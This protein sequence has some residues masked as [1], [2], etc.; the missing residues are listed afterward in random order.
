MARNRILYFSLF[1]LSLTFVYFYGGKIP[2][3]L[4][5]IVII[6]P[7]VSF[8]FT[9]IA[10]KRF[11]FTESI[12]KKTVIK[13]ES[14]NYTLNIHNPD[15]FLYPFIKVNFYGEDTVFS[16]QFQTKSFSLLPFQKKSF[17]F[18]ILCKYRGYYTVGIKSIEFEDYLGIFRL[19]RRPGATK[20]I[21]VNPRLINL[22]SFNIKTNYM[23]ESHSILNKYFED[24]TTISDTRKYAYGDSLKRIHWKL[25]AKVNQLMVKNFEG[26]SKTNCVIM[27]DLQKNNY[28]NEQNIVLEDKLIECT[29]AVVYHCLS[30]WIPINFVYHSREVNKIEA[31]NTTDFEKIYDLLSNVSFDQDIHI[32]DLLNIYSRDNAN[33]MD[34]IIFTSNIDYDLYN[35]LYNLKAAGHDVNIV[36]VCAEDLMVN[37]KNMVRDILTGLTEIGVDTYKVNVDDN[38]ETVLKYSSA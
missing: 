29:V 36:Y 15:F 37:D 30:N 24:I 32:K 23:S 26:T 4:F 25:S 35:E 12:D 8:L 14:V 3:M 20:T 1:F 13:G 11:R 6:L 2:Y 5:Y 33:K 16:R 28:S 9:F 34:L 17:T 7:I 38:I 18:G 21:T 19:S 27:L 31:K 10:C 22:D